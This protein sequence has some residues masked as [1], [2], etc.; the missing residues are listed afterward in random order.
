[1]QR[2]GGLLRNIDNYIMWILPVGTRQVYNDVWFII[3][4]CKYIRVWNSS[5][6]DV[7]SKIMKRL[8]I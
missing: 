1:M 5:T 4:V 3:K 7:L 6:I 2:N 8:W